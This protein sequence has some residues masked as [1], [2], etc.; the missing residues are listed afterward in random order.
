M[1]PVHNYNEG[2][3]Y[4]VCLTVTSLSSGIMCTSTYCSKITTIE[5]FSFGGQAFIG[6]YPINIDS[7][8]NDNIGI[9][10]LYR[11]INNSWEYM[12]QREFWE[13]GY[14][15]FANKPVG[16]YL[17]QTELTENSVDNSNYAP[18]YYEDAISWK[19]ANVFNLTNDQQ[20]AINISF[21]ELMDSPSG[22]G[23]IS[24]IVVGSIS[25]NQIQNIFTDHVLVQ[26]FNSNMELIDYTY[27]DISGDFQFNGLAIGMC[28]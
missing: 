28:I 4:D 11:K 3:E 18:A 23:S 12:D 9:A 14:Y 26:L 8:E 21:R 5:Y 1:N 22:I 6:D 27:S 7:S 20:F 15:W 16:Q 10:Y 2:G 13:Y 24:G 25:C 17:I 19:N